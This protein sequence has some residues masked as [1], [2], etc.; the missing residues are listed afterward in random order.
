MEFSEVLIR[1]LN[2]REALLKQYKQ[3]LV[4]LRGPVSMLS[5]LVYWR[6]LLECTCVVLACVP[7]FGEA[8]PRS[9]G[10]MTGKCEQQQKIRQHMCMSTYK[11]VGLSG[12][13]GIGC[14]FGVFLCLLTPLSQ[15]SCQVNSSSIGDWL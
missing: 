10:E 2:A 4:E 8:V 3:E 9:A 11:S 13:I 1:Q 14:P 5:A 6:W 15:K 12:V 7:S